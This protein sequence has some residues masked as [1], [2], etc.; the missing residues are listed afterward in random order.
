MAAGWRDLLALVL[1][2]MNTFVEPSAARTCAVSAEDRTGEIDEGERVYTVT[3]ERV[4]T[5]AA[6]TCS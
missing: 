5:V 4:Y 1:R 2:W 3:G 6:D